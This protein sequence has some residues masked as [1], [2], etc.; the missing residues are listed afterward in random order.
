MASGAGAGP[1]GMAV[2]HESGM[3]RWGLE[4]RETVQ[5]GL[6]WMRFRFEGS[7]QYERPEDET[8]VF[9]AVASGMAVVLCSESNRRKSI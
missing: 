4:R 8:P 9:R 6:P 5:S 7:A 2:R 3:S 1:G